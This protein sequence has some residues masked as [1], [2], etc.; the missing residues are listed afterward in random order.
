MSDPGTL[1]GEVERGWRR[2]WALPWK[3]KGTFIGIAGFLLLVI[4]GS[5]SGS[6]DEPSKTSPDRTATSTSAAT[7]KATD[8]PKPGSTSTTTAPVATSI[9]SNTTAATST[10]T[11]KAASTT[12]V[13][14]TS[15]PVPATSTPVPTAATN[16]PIP[17]DGHTWYTSSASNA[18][19]YYCDLDPEWRDLSA[20][21]LRSYSSE[22]ALKA[23]W[24]SS[25]TKFPG[26][27]C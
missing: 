8:T 5:V 4:A 11:A 21:N 1:R 13:P 7:A 24:G 26:S 22:A 16:T 9:P 12:P 18:T 3:W 14:D 23:V 2:F 6:S 20:S 17:G 27:N 19:R 25:R 15:T 10:N